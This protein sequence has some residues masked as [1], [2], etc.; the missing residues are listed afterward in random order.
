VSYMGI[1]SMVISGSTIISS[2]MSD[3]LTRKIGTYAVTVISV[4]M[5]AFAIGGFSFAD[6]FGM[7]IVLAVP[8]GLGAGS[9]DAAMNNYIALHYT[10]KHMSWL[11]CFWGVGAII[12]P[13]VM[14]YALSVS[15]WNNGYRIIAVTQT[16]IG[17]IL[18]VSLPL[19]RVNKGRSASNDGQ[20][21]VGLI[22]ALRI[23]GVPCLLLG[24]LAYCAA[25]FTTLGWSSTY[26]VEVRGMAEERAAAFASLFYIGMTVGR[27]FGGFVVD[28]VGDRR[29]IILGTVISSLGVICIAVPVEIVTLAG[30]TVIG[31]G[32]APIYPCIIHSTPSNFGKENS[33][34]IIGIQMASAYTGST[35]MPPLYGL[36]GRLFGFWIMPFYLAVFMVLM[37]VM[38]ERTFKLTAHR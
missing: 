21:S 27:F 3:M 28:R 32:Y 20:K 34:A 11:H 9:I 16:V 1:V 10:S 2:L 7:L 17:V 35:F 33:G 6:E 8:Y 18:L 25:E 22:G 4:F 24:F 14:S 5:T 15:V 23:K 38:I 29:M 26:L 19:W 37:T 31:L 12:S 30:F 36:L 13:F